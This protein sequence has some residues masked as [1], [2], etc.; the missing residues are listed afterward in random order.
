MSSYFLRC[1]LLAMGH[2]FPLGYLTFISDLRKCL[3]GESWYV[4]LQLFQ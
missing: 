4:F 1:S 3:H 2:G